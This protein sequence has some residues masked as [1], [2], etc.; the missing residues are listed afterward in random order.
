MTSTP[1]QQLIIEHIQHD[2]P[3]PFADY[4]RMAL[5]EPGY[6]Y[7]V[8]G[9]ARMGWQGDY[10]TS[11]DLSPLFASCIGRQLQ[12]MWE[13]LERPTPFIVLE[14]GAGRHH[15]AQEV[16]TWAAQ[17]SPDLHTVLDYHTEDIH[18]GQDAV[19]SLSLPNTNL[20]PHVILSNELV[21]A[22]PVHIVEVYQS[23]LYELY[24]DVQDG[25]LCE[26]LNDLS[27]P[28]VACYLDS[29]K[30]PWATFGDGW[31]AEINLDALRWMERSTQTLLATAQTSKRGCFLLTIDYGDTASELYTAHRRGGTLAC[32]FQHKLSEQPLARPGKQDITAHVNFTALI[33]E[34]A[35]HGLHLHTLTTQQQW[36]TNI[37]LYEELARM[38]TR[39]FAVIDSARASDRGQIALLQW[40][41]L[42][43][44]VA[45]LTDPR[46]MGHFKVL[47]LQTEEA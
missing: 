3:M 19:S 42:R 35:R 47:I 39:E 5:Y 18:V 24:I 14:Q 17:Q 46:G 32:Y 28:D 27:S 10:Y 45:A 37:G 44:G 38:R 31:R 1:L 25:H 41:N 12:Q 15:L 40:Y 4:M 9:P 16:H 20:T 2:G 34:G 6:G 21:D 22:F 33:N 36:L 26:V 43:T 13:H 29:Y 30:I 11:T 8:S 7:Y 23:R